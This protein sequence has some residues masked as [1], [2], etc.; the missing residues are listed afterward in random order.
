MKILTGVISLGNKRLQYKL[1]HH[2]APECLFSMSRVLIIKLIAPKFSHLKINFGLFTSSHCQRALPSY[3]MSLTQ[4]HLCRHLKPPKVLLSARCQRASGC[5]TASEH[6]L[7]Q[8]LG[9]DISK[10]LSESA[11]YY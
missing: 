4:V 1:F 10:H 7:A 11:A 5:A 8:C 9:I 6:L 3:S 2:T